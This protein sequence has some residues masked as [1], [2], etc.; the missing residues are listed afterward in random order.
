[1]MPLLIHNILENKH[2]YGLNYIEPV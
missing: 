1:M 2:K